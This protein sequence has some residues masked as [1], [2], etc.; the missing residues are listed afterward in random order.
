[1][2]YVHCIAGILNIRPDDSIIQDILS[3]RCP[4]D[5]RFSCLEL[6]LHFLPK[7]SDFE[8]LAPKHQP[9]DHV[10]LIFFIIIFLSAFFSLSSSVSTP[11]SLHHVLF[12]HPII[13]QI[14]THAAACSSSL[15]RTLALSHGRHSAESSVV[16][17][18]V[19]DLHKRYYYDALYID[20]HICIR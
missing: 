18:L 12:A 13:P 9:F 17:S 4:R 11:H 15:P 3:F 10:Y 6:F 19:S 5:C 14:Y 2:W 7:I 16:T 1:M 20:K 8:V